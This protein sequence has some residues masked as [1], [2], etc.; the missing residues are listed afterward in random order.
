MSHKIIGKYIK[1]LDFKIPNPKTFFLLTKDI[2]N[3]RINIDIKSNR[4]KE[5]I[6]EVVTSLIL[7]PTKEN[8][9]KIEARIEF[10]TL[11]ELPFNKL[12]KKVVE[13]I[14]LIKVPTEVY[15]EL[16]RIFINLFESSGFKDVKVN[17]KVDFQKLYNMRKV[18]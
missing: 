12:E 13:E 17:E 8:F 15:S 3:Y 18:Q 14:I 6:I 2:T 10:A 11:I 7:N 9:E 5:N 4:V 1:C 16:R